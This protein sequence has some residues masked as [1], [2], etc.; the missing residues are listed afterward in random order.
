M[1]TQ[2]RHLAQSLGQ[3]VTPD[4]CQIVAGVFLVSL[5]SEGGERKARAGAPSPILWREQITIETE[6]RSEQNSAR[7]SA[8]RGSSCMDRRALW[9]GTEENKN[10]LTIIGLQFVNASDVST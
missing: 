6:D 3:K 5:L 9:Q 10:Y 2:R 4:P 1:K 7:P 8:D